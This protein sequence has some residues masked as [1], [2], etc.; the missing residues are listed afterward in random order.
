VLK[1]PTPHRL[2]LAIYPFQD[3]NGCLGRTLLLMFLLHCNNEKLAE[4]VYYLAI[5]R[6]IKQPND[7]DFY[8][9]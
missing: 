4:V 3:G 1:I 5:D 9:K 7:I 6:H 8:P 2:F